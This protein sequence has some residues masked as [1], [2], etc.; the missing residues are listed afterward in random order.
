[1]NIARFRNPALPADWRDLL[2]V[3]SGGAK[4]R[5]VLMMAAL[6]RRKRH[7]PFLQAFVRVVDTLPDLKLLLAGAGPEEARVRAAVSSLGLRDRVVFC[8]HRPDPEALFALADLSVLTS[9]REGLPRVAV[10]S[11]AAGCP[12]VVQDLP[13]IDEII[14]HGRNGMIAGGHDVEDT[15]RQ[16]SGLLRNDRRLNE[17]RQGALA[18]D[19]SAWALDALGQRSTQLYGVPVRRSRPIIAEHEMGLA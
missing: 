1:M 6:E 18:T 7:V 17:L 3:T 19:V 13:G 12:M 15:V 8:G 16:M 11:V 5:V 9:A 4:P 14:D 2:G 10:Q